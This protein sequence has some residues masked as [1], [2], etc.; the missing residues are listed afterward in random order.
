MN[1]PTGKGIFGWKLDYMAG[2]D[3]VVMAEKAVAASSLRP[4]PSS[5][6]IEFDTS[7][8]KASAVPSTCSEE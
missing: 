1:Y 2:G 5:V 6:S 7:I 4:V 3:P 8:T